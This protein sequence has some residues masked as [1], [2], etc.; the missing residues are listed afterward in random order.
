ML[1]TIEK[2][3]ATKSHFYY[4][5]AL[6]KEKQMADQREKWWSMKYFT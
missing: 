6:D 3:A 2:M 5:I 4:V 1:A